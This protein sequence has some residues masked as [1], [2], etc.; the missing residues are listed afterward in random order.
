[1]SESTRNSAQ[2]VWVNVATEKLVGPGR[3]QAMTLEITEVTTIIVKW[4]EPTL[5]NGPLDGYFV[6][7]TQRDGHGNV[8]VFQKAPYDTV[9]IFKADSEYTM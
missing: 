6:N 5:R 9:H 7:I 2:I 1:M 4:F 8:R 3:V